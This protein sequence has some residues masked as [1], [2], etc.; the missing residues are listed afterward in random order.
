MYIHSVNGEFIATK[1]FRNI[2]KI[3]KDTP[4]PIT[5]GLIEYWPFDKENKKAKI[6]MNYG[7]TWNE[8]NCA[9]NELICDNYEDEWVQKMLPILSKYNVLKVERG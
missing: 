7:Y 3:F 1:L 6:L 9:A 5:L 8:I 4:A 2:R